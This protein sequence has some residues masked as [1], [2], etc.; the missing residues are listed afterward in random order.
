MKYHKLCSVS[1]ETVTDRAREVALIV[2][3]S[4]HVLQ[5]TFMN[6]LALSQLTDL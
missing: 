4:Y 2:Q 6:L 3:V 5:C 1:G